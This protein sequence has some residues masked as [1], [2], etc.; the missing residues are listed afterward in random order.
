M[1][2]EDVSLA[3]DGA[4]WW[5]NRFDEILKHRGLGGQERSELK[6][7]REYMSQKIE[8]Y[9]AQLKEGEA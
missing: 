8:Q 5:W 9:K 7:N 6:A 1:N 4:Q 3:M 2:R